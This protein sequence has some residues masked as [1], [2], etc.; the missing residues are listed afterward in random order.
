[1]NIKNVQLK[2]GICPICW[3]AITKEWAGPDPCLGTICKECW[4]PQVHVFEPENV[5]I[6]AEKHIVYNPLLNILKYDFDWTGT[7]VRINGQLGEVIY[8]QANLS[9]VK[10]SSLEDNETPFTDYIKGLG[11]YDL[12]RILKQRGCSINPP[13][14]Q[15]KIHSPSKEKLLSKPIAAVSPS[16]FKGY[17]TGIFLGDD[18][19]CDVPL[20]D[21]LHAFAN[22]YVRYKFDLSFLFEYEGGFICKETAIKN[23]MPNDKGTCHGIQIIDNGQ[24]FQKFKTLISAESL[25][26][27]V[28]SQPE[29][30]EKYDLWMVMSTWAA[31]METLLRY[32]WFK[33]PLHTAIE[34]VWNYYCKMQD[35]L[36]NILRPDDLKNVLV[37]A[38]N[39]AAN[40]C[41]LAY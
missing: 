9:C 39:Q 12:L 28:F 5:L 20:A 40:H 4:S 26:K 36:L 21:M 17:I 32:D 23:L 13:D 24:E 37:Y 1:M 41:G 6:K 29:K 19:Y 33:M 3:K 30:I 16:L 25:E 7:K 27:L 2:K 38:K 15:L 14:P 35:V 11:Y 22:I 34:D 8:S 10:F 31:I 18:G